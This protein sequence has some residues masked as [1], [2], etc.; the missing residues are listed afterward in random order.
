MQ[1]TGKVNRHSESRPR[2]SHHTNSGMGSDCLSTITHSVN[3]RLTAESEI[4]IFTPRLASTL[5]AHLA[6][7]LSTPRLIPLHLA[8]H[9]ASHQCTLGDTEPRTQCPAAF[10]S[11]KAANGQRYLPLCMARLG[12]LGSRTVQLPALDLPSENMQ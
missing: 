7:H 6:S 2:G 9:L 12:I 3:M 11:E 8:S 4:P 5:R 10:H 1:P